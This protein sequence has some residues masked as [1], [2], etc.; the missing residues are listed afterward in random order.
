M[1][2]PSTYVEFDPPGPRSKIAAGLLAILLPIGLHRFYLGYPIVGLVQFALVWFCGIG[3]LWCIVEGIL[4]FLDV[5][6][7]SHGRRLRD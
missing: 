7:D 6:R 2:G 1:Y 4:C 3:S 5:M